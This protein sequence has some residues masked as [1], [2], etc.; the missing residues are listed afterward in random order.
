MIALF[1]MA[2]PREIL[3]LEWSEVIFPATAKNYMLCKRFRRWNSFLGSQDG[4]RR[5]LD[6]FP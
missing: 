4:A 1:G 6:R 3:L 2:S 5:P